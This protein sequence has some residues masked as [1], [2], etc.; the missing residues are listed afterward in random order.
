VQLQ[1][2][3]RCHFGRGYKAKRHNTTATV[4]IEYGPTAVPAGIGS[5]G[6]LV[7]RKTCRS[8]IATSP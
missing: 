3:A 6:E 2:A 1:F 5:I 7:D 4:V 8:S